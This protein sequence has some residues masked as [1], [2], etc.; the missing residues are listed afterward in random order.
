MPGLHRATASDYWASREASIIYGVEYRTVEVQ[1]W[2]NFE[3][4]SL[5]IYMYTYTLITII[6]KEHKI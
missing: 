1:E 4:L 2:L 3:A 5:S 6:K